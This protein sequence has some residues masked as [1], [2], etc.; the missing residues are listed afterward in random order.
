MTRARAR[1]SDE[2]L[3]ATPSPAAVWRWLSLNARTPPVRW[4]ATISPTAATFISVAGN[5][6][7][8]VPH[9]S[10]SKF[11]LSR[12]SAPFIAFPAIHRRFGRLTGRA[13]SSGWI[14]QRT[15]GLRLAPRGGAN[16]S[17]R[18]SIGNAS[19]IARLGRKRQEGMERQPG[20]RSSIRRKGQT[21]IARNRPRNPTFLQNRL[22]LQCRLPSPIN[23]LS[24]L[25]RRLNILSKR[26]TCLA[27]YQP[28]TRYEL[29]GLIVL[30]T[31]I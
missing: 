19:R 16:H 15:C 24:V 31:S 25:H 13:L 18:Q 22:L 4:A 29:S 2:G 5:G 30:D 7:S 23:R 8:H 26:A 20:G 6:R 9:A 10:L 27:L 11:L 17:K 28:S 3:P 1:P 21:K 14:A 12:E